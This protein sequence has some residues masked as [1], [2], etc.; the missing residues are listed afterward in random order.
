MEEGLVCIEI[1][2]TL[3][4]VFILYKEK[5]IQEKQLTVVFLLLCHDSSRHCTPSTETCETM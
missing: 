5:S 4:F 1:Y 2:V 3:R